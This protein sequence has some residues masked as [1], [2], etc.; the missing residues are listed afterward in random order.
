[1]IKNDQ[2]SLHKSRSPLDHTILAPLVSFISLPASFEAGLIN[3]SGTLTLT[4]IDHVS[5]MK[6][7]VSRTPKSG[8]IT[9][10][11]FRKHSSIHG[12]WTPPDPYI[13]IIGWKTRIYKENHTRYGWESRLKRVRWTSALP[14]GNH[15]RLYVAYR[16][17]VYISITFN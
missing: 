8:E 5:I 10:K 9:V 17:S 14:L 13:G 16:C 4:Y 3:S 11:S 2:V 12:N 7:N 6:S 1:M 15:H